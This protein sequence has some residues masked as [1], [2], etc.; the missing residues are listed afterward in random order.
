MNKKEVLYRITPNIRFLRSKIA[1]HQMQ[2]YVS[3]LLSKDTVEKA[4]ADEAYKHDAVNDA[5]QLWPKRAEA[6]NR[7]IDTIFQN[8]PDCQGLDSNQKRIIREDILFCRF[9]YGFMPAEYICFNFMQKTAEERKSFIS[10]SD[11]MRY[12]YSMNDPIDIM[13]FNDKMRTYQ[14]FGRYYHREIISLSSQRDY[15]K[16]IAFIQ[17]HPVFVKKQVLESCG[18]SIERIDINECGKTNRELFDSFIIQGKVV[19]EEVVTQGKATAVFNASS[20]NTIRCI[21]VNT[22]HGVEAPYCFM[23][24]GRA[25]SF[26]DNGGAGGI[27][28]GIDEKSG[29]LNTDGYDEMR[30]IYDRH[31]DSGTV[32][33]GR[34]LPDWETMLNICKEMAEKMPSVRL[35]GW[36]L[37]Y[38][39]KDGWIVIEG[40]G[41]SQFIGPQTIWQRGIKP[42][43]QRFMKEM[44]LLV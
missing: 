27:L 20:V 13:V 19:L 5:V 21:T 34:E 1:K 18:K 30:H 17:K 39:D 16:F 9:A 4:E 24:I 29:V 25:G 11:H 7:T 23:K 37:A 42:E 43:V 38:S 2:K 12:I 15:Q 3:H 6:D 40:N 28:V 26:V 14:R 35:I 22:N 36:D 10:E 33:K 32:F 44:D 8:A 31:P 41:M